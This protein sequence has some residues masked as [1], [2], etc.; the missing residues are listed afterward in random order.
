MTLVLDKLHSIRC[1]N[2]QMITSK[3]LQA[4]HYGLIVVLLC[5]LSGDTD[6]SHEKCQ[7]ELVSRPRF[8]PITPKQTSRALPIRQHV[9]MVLGWNVCIKNLQLNLKFCNRLGNSVGYSS[10]VLGQFLTLE[11]C[12][13]VLVSKHKFH[14]LKRHEL[15]VI[16]YFLPTV[17]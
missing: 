16:W 12:L 6:E 9:R 11:K 17:V 7:P 1:Y 10:L 13:P 15:I 4:I 5:Y 8:K 2:R 14:L 3:D